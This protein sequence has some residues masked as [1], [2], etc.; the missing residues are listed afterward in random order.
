MLMNQ[1]SPTNSLKLGRLP[2]SLKASASVPINSNAISNPG[3]STDE[4]QFR[5][6]NSPTSDPLTH[7]FTQDNHSGRAEKTYSE[8]PYQEYGRN[9]SGQNRTSMFNNLGAEQLNVMVNALSMAATQYLIGNSQAPGPDAS[10]PMKIHPENEHT[11]FPSLNSVAS[12]REQDPSERKKLFGASEFVNDFRKNSEA[13]TNGDIN[14]GPINCPRPPASSV[15]EVYNAYRSGSLPPLPCL[16]P[17]LPNVTPKLPPWNGCPSL[18]RLSSTFTPYLSSPTRAGSRM[19]QNDKVFS[20]FVERVHKEEE[21]TRLKDSPRA[22]LMEAELWQSF[23]TMTTEMVITKSGRR[24]FPSFKVR[25]SGLDR[26]SKYIML[27]DLIGRDDHRYKFHNGKWTV[28]GKADPE[29]LRK[30]YIHPDS[31]STGEEWMH[32]PI[33]FHKLKLTNNVTERQPFQAVLNS[34][35]KYVPRF[36]IVR[37]DHLNKVN[38]CDFVTFVFDETEFIAVTAYQNERITQLKIDNN[39]FAK[40]FRDNGTGRREKKRQRVQY[41]GSIHSGEFLE[42]AEE[43]PPSYGS[44]M[45]VNDGT[46]GDY[47]PLSAAHSPKDHLMNPDHFQR[48]L[49]RGPL[50]APAHPLIGGERLRNAECTPL[51][52]TN[53]P[54]KPQSLDPDQNNNLDITKR[55]RISNDWSRRGKWLGECENNGALHS[56]RTQHTVHHC[57]NTC[58]SPSSLLWKNLPFG[59]KLSKLGPPPPSEAAKWMGLNPSIFDLSLSGQT[60]LHHVASTNDI[61]TDEGAGNTTFNRC[62]PHLPN[63]LAV[64]V[65]LVSSS[66]LWNNFKMPMTSDAAISA[67]AALSAFAGNM[68]KMGGSK[69]SNT[70]DEISGSVGEDGNETDQLDPSTQTLPPSADQNATP[71]T[72]SIPCWKMQSPDDLE[73]SPR[74]RHSSANN[75]EE[76]VEE[77][78]APERDNTRIKRKFP[79]DKED[80]QTPRRLK[81]ATKNFTI[82]C[83]LDNFKTDESDDEQNSD[84][85]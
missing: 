56:A 7:S 21:M 3:V 77:E 74:S 8:F 36:H 47:N 54:P 51:S 55:T 65:D 31:P 44:C 60:Q 37:A 22:E 2:T 13:F 11:E 1:A 76:G 19:P 84:K 40:G 10:F 42:E 50:T 63:F 39:P 27:L 46:E 79:S 20:S 15:L 69:K 81:S 9:N 43:T 80:T 83:L 58:P 33:S 29:P 32:K 28:A 52:F 73:C 38:F 14:T 34:M 23:H 59:N 82:S 12:N 48:N 35:H 41:G 49:I 16:P 62:N 6:L 66:P 68:N 25:V 72:C 26:N 85:Q 30:P 24:M 67:L 45:S 70:N 53:E 78:T 18:V 4:P 17:H 5:H 61:R 57:P 71:S 75:T 64:P